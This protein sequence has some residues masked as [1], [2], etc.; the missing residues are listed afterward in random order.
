[1]WRQI[2]IP[3]TVLTAKSATALAQSEAE[4]L[5]Q[6]IAAVVVSIARRSTYSEFPR[7][8]FVRWTHVACPT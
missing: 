5:F 8:K 2:A 4:R 1:M 6:P 3:L 7:G